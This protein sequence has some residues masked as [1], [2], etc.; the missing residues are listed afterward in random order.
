MAWPLLIAFGMAF[1]GGMAFNMAS[2]D[3]PIMAFACRMAF[4]LGM[5]FESNIPGGST[6]SSEIVIGDHC[7]SADGVST[8]G[9]A[10]GV[11]TGLA[12]GKSAFPC[13]GSCALLAVLATSK[14]ATSRNGVAALAT[15]PPAMSLGG[16]RTAIALMQHSGHRCQSLK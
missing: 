5:D 14:D 7:G 1:A 12:D 9:S 3:I 10:D 13:P 15:A 8:G 16:P 4:A 11:F 2:E 6:S